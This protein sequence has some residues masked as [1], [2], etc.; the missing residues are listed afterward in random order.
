LSTSTNSANDRAK[1]SSS[2]SGGGGGGGGSAYLESYLSD[3]TVLAALY[4]VMPCPCLVNISKEFSAR[5]VLVSVT[6]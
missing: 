2:S 3:T 4:E 6:A 1:S 5:G